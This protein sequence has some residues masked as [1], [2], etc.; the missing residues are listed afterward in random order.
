MYVCINAG[1]DCGKGIDMNGHI[2][3][4]ETNGDGDFTSSTSSAEILKK[5]PLKNCNPAQIQRLDDE[6]GES[7]QLGL[8]RQYQGITLI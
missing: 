7:P 5:Q 4:R 6:S 8:V 1:G 3:A 2:C